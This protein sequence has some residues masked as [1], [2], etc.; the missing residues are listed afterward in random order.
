[1][2]EAREDTAMNLK[3]FLSEEKCC[4]CGMEKSH[5]ST[6]DGA[7]REGA[8]FCCDRCADETGC[9]CEVVLRQSQPLRSVASRSGGQLPIANRPGRPAKKIREA[10]TAVV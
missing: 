10:D 5:W 9:Q 2:N 8:L 7:T 3:T 4:Q 1:M 6:P